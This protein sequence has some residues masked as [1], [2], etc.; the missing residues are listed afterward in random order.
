MGRPPLPPDEKLSRQLVV[1]F[2]QAEFEQLEA[3]AQGKALGPILRELG[4]RWARGRR[5]R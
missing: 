5:Q 2:T 4:V 3:A 1:R